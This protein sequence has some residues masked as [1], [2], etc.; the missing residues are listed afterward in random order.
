MLAKKYEWSFITNKSIRKFETFSSLKIV[1][2][3]FCAIQASTRSYIQIKGML[4][5]STAWTFQPKNK[6][7]N[8]KN[9]GKIF[10]QLVSLEYTIYY[11]T[12]TMNSWTT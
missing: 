3:R 1:T 11:T 5:L 12:K 4:S 6:T 9:Q 8:E 10:K 7:L 2:E